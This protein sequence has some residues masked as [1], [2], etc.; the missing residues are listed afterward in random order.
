MLSKIYSAAIHGLTAYVVSVQVDESNGLPRSQTLGNVSASVKEAIERVSIVL[1]N[2]GLELPP[3]KITIN[4]QPA[5]LRKSGSSFDLPIFMGTLLALYP[6]S[7]FPYENYGFL[8]ELGLDGEIQHVPG[9]LPMVLA[10]EEA[11]LKGVFVPKDNEPEARNSEK[12]EVIACSHITEILELCKISYGKREGGAKRRPP[13][14]GGEKESEESFQENKKIISSKDSGKG[15]SGYGNG[16]EEEQNLDFQDVLGQSY[17]VRAALIAAA[18]HHALLFSGP[19]GTGKT[20]IAKRIPGILPKMSKQEK[21]DLTK[22]YSIA[23]CLPS[24]E[25]L[26]E[27]RPFRAPHSAVSQNTLLGGMSSGRLIPGELALAGKG[28]LFLDELPLFKKESIEALRGPM[29]EKRV[30]LHRLQQFFSYPVDCLFVAAMN[31]CP[32]G[33][34]PDRNRCHCTPGQIRAYQ[35]G[36]SK[37]ILER[38]DLCVSLPAIS[39]Q[40]A[41]TKEK[42]ISTKCLREQVEK[43]RKMQESRFF[44]EETLRWNGDM[45]VN[46]VNK[47]CILGSEEREYMENI[48]KLKNLSMRTY[49]KILKLART[50][51]DLEEEKDITINHLAE[52]V[53]YRG[54]EEEL[55]AL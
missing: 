5:D 19:A 7:H 28:V 31:P 6:K 11:G 3:K 20:M 39:L 1:K 48:F 10:L 29:E 4:L 55:F 23:S 42:G 30:T 18:G 35:R 54:L 9:V 14:L 25:G 12:L 52:A 21:L 15:Y 16:N 22:I 45:H 50:I 51:A 8:G 17:G 2:L 37:P 43:A 41:L 27:K 47:Y 32:C 26:I 46:E 44:S 40:E 24:K 49:H 53:S 33:Y 36:I 34:F 13:S 38:M